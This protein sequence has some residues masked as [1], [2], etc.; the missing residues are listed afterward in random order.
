MHTHRVS[1]SETFGWTHCCDPYAYH[2]QAAHGGVTIREECKCGAVRFRETTG[3]T[4]RT[5]H[6]SKWE[7]PESGE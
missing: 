7:M 4:T 2:S 3:P 6:T 1:K 5:S